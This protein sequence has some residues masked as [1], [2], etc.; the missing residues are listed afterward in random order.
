MNT[1]K[2]TYTALG[3][4]VICVLAPLAVP[5]GQV[6]I[7]MATFAVMLMAAL[8]GKSMGTAAALVY[9]L[10]GAAGL[11]VFA[12]Y[13]AGISVLLGPTGG[14][15]IGYLFLAWCTGF[16]SEKGKWQLVAGMI[17]GT[18]IL[19]LFGTVWFVLVTGMDVMGALAVCVIPFLIGDALKMAA[20]F[21]LQNALFRIRHMVRADSRG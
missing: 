11:P 9:M 21:A 3:A 6:P 14:Y 17:G 18:A 4:A 12:S 5:V 1:R 7:S 8:L 19:Y 2:I 16:G 15:V 20:V 10:L 13:K